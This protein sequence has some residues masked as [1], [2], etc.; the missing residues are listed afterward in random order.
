M[1]DF[2]ITTILLGVPSVDPMANHLWRVFQG[3]EGPT[4]FSGGHFQ[5]VSTC[6]SN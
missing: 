5:D 1:K 2:I 4:I 3:L 6:K